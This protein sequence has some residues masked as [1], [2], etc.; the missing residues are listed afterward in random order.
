[1][2]QLPGGR[3]SFQVNGLAGRTYVLQASQD[4]QQWTDLSTNVATG[5]PLNFT[6]QINAAFPQR[7]FRLKSP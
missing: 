3:L 2:T 5:G 7:F 4:M 6:N 1:M